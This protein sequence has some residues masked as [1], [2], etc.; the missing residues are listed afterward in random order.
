M[1]YPIYILHSSADVAAEQL[2]TRDVQRVL[3]SCLIRLR[4][5]YKKREWEDL[6]SA[7]VKE[8]GFNYYWLAYFCDCLN[9]R[10]FL[11]Q[12]VHAEIKSLRVN[13]PPDLR[14][15]QQTPFPLYVKRSYPNQ[16]VIEAYRTAYA[17]T[18]T[19][20]EWS[21]RSPPGWFTRLGNSLPSVGG[22][23][24]QDV[25]CE[26]PARPMRAAH[27]VRGRTTRPAA[28]DG[29]ILAADGS[30]TGFKL[31]GLRDS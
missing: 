28:R 4:G 29:E 31:Y 11:S 8:D 3:K 25:L 16:P 21:D 30:P 27:P 17:A 22:R 6:L 1:H 13:L 19:F 5:A 7:W 24:K 9:Q 12:D 20:A 26:Q 23:G 2:T 18:R 15:K 10:C 14:C